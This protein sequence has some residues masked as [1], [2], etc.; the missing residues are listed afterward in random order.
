MFNDYTVRFFFFLP[1]VIVSGKAIVGGVNGL[2]PAESV[3]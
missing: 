2:V 1:P 3:S